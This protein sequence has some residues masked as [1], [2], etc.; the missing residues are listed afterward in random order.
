MIRKIVL[1]VMALI[2][3]IAAVQPILAQDI[4]FGG[5]GTGA[6][7]QRFAV[8]QVVPGLTNQGVTGASNNTGLLNNSLIEASGLQP[9]RRTTFNVV[10]V[11]VGDS[12][13]MV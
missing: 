6:G 8:P 4:S 13:V 5:R 12:T 2:L 3:T 10:D 9:N 1:T 11:G 7:S